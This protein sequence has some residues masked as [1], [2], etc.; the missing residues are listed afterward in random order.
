MVKKETN[1]SALPKPNTTD[2]P[3]E[4]RTATLR[5]TR[6][7]K[8]PVIGEPTSIWEESH[9]GETCLFDEMTPAEIDEFKAEKAAMQAKERKLGRSSY[10]PQPEGMTLDDL[11]KDINKGAKR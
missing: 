1:M 6:A 10:R 7:S 3:E 5:E 11:V 4:E 2:A 9:P 8:K